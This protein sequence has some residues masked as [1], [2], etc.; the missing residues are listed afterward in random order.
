LPSGLRFLFIKLG[1]RLRSLSGDIMNRPITIKQIAQLAGVNPST[2]SRV[3]NPDCGH[4]ISEKIRKK[5]LAIA[6]K[7][8]Y[9]PKNS[10]R[11]LAH[12][13][14]FNLGVILH[15]VEVDLASPTFALVFGAFCREALLHGYQAVL[16]PVQA[17]DLDRQVLNNIRAGNAD[18][19]LVGASLMGT[20]TL[21]EL[22]KK[23]IPVVS[24]TSDTM[25]DANLPN[26][27]VFTTDN[28]PAFEELFTTV[29]SRGF[30]SFAL[31]GP[32][33]KKYSSRYEFYLN[34]EKYGVT[35]SETIEYLGGS[36]HIMGWGDAEFAARQHIEQLKKHKLIICPN[37][38]IAMGL[39]R[40]LTQA[41]LTVGKDISVIGYDNIEENP[42]FYP[43]QTPFLTTIAK[44]DPR[45]GREMVRTLLKMLKNEKV[46]ERIMQPADFILREGSLGRI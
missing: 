4:S 42:N 41:G 19:Y 39:C 34:S 36:S 30:D 27:C 26:V 25:L 29:K 14:S 23:H 9:V 8:E 7:N 20:E 44:D 43:S 46:P 35:L 12:G 15:T 2:V 24:Y 31:F 45:A 11:S 22:E 32:A 5:V 6:E 21:N 1:N 18:G 17:G 33:G 10:A 38:L 40:A 37:D 28:A 3:F 16:L 13:K